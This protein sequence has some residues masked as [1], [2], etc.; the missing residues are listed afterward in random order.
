MNCHNCGTEVP[1][2][3]RYCHR[4]GADERVEG[5]DAK[6]RS[7]YAVHPGEPVVS[8]NL[9]SS[10]MPLAT[11]G[12]PQTYKFA[13]A[14]GVLVPVVAAVLGY[15]AFAFAAA[16]VVVPTAYMLYLYDVNEWEDQPVPVVIGTV[17]VAG[18]LAL[19]FTYL[20]REVLL[21]T[22]LIG[23]GADGASTIDGERL[24]IYGL[25][26]PI[27]AMLLAQ[28]GATFLASR[29]KFDDLIDGL[30]FGVAAGAA[31]AAVETLV[32]QRML[33]TTGLGTQDNPDAALWASLVLNDAMVKPVIYG[34]AAGIAVAAFSGVNE[35]PGRFSAHHLRA[36]VESIVAVAAYWIGVELLRGTVSGSGGALLGLVWGVVIAAALLLRI[37]FVLHLAVLEAALEFAARGSVPRTANQ[38]IGF[39]PTCEM[40]LMHEASFCSACGTASRA[41]SKPAR[42]EMATFVEETR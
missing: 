39:C 18:L 42:R 19:G 23:R 20:W 13:F 16:A 7:A 9:V 11:G 35:G 40:P 15:L 31:Y 33:F 34:A 17:V 29:D 4:C 6:R 32:I 26:V 24:L 36:V 2:S 1:E 8:F 30:T 5:G 3:A 37:R 14:V 41:A 10:L 12:V 38:G 21:P 25:V 27:G 22:Q 28:V